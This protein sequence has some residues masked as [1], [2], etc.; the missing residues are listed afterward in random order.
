[1]MNKPFFVID[2][3][4][5]ISAN[6]IKESVSAKA[7]D[8]VILIGKIAISRDVLNEY[9]EVL[10]REKL[11]KYLS[12]EKRQNA[13]KQLKRYAINFFPSETVSVCRDAKDNKFLDLAL[14]CQAKC[15]I[16]GDS[17]LLVL[18]PFRYI[19]IMSSAEFLQSFENLL[20]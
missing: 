11:D 6:L 13:L 19:P 4:C 3:N 17:D 16:S 15:I 8:K 9:T 5:F 18:N 20:K 10:Y 12:E 1:M 14:A 7:F 2:T